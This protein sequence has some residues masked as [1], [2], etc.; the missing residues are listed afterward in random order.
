MMAM[1]GAD[2][3]TYDNA[4]ALKF[5]F[6]SCKKANIIKIELNGMDLYDITFYKY[7]RKTYDCPL[8]KEFNNIYAEDMKKIIEEYTGLYL[9]L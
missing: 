8:V 9:S 7:N 5:W 4:G 1:I 2:K 3:F 6:K